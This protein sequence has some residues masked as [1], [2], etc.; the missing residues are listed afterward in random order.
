MC[1]FVLGDFS[2]P[3]LHFPKVCFYGVCL[4]NLMASL[5]RILALGAATQNKMLL[6]S[7]TERVVNS[8]GSSLSR[9]SQC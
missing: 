2:V 3:A 6:S 5:S 7:L 8:S 1:P 9:L 4:Q